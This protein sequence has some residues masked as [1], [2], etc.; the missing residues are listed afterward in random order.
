[1]PLLGRKIVITR[2][3]EANRDTA[4][5]LRSKGAHVISCPTIQIQFLPPSRS[6]KKAIRLLQQNPPGFDWILFL[7]GLGVQSFSRMVGRWRPFSSNIQIGAVGPKTARVLDKNRW[8][9]HR[10]ADVYRAA[11]LLRSM[12]PVKEKRVLLVRG[13]GGSFDMAGA[14]RKRGAFVKEIHPYKTVSAAFPSARLKAQVTKGAEAVFFTSGSTVRYFCRFFNANQRRKIFN[15]AVAVS[16]GPET[17]RALRANGIRSV[18]E[19][20]KATIEDMVALLFEIF[21][22]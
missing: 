20:A 4:S 7:S 11:G 6:I 14:L 5:S 13:E 3:R 16:V 15:S 9:V 19:A 18:R 12:G 17:T 22:S 21:I 10:V 8:P 2:S 1:M